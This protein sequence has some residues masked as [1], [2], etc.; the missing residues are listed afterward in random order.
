MERDADESDVPRLFHRLN[1]QLGV[2]LANAELLESR[3]GDHAQ[4]ARATQIV[5]GA[6]EAMAA[7]Q[8]LRGIAEPVS[9]R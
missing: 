6:I 1:N 9:D 4:R 7:V 8:E 5:A 3:L 2:I